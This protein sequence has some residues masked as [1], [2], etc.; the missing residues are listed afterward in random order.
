MTI[1]DCFSKGYLNKKNRLLYILPHI[2]KLCLYA[3]RWIPSPPLA[4]C[5][6]KGP[7]AAQGGSSTYSTWR[8]PL[9]SLLYRADTDR[10]FPINLTTF[11]LLNQMM[12]TFLYTNQSDHTS[13]MQ[14][15]S[16]GFT[17]RQF[18]EVS[19]SKNFAHQQSS[20]CQRS[21]SQ[22]KAELCG[23]SCWYCRPR[24]E[25]SEC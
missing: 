14:D 5:C 17:S 7:L 15:E 25:R 16:K 9:H 10:R 12:L 1:N 2:L 24:K 19:L 11:Y 21:P 4:N 8:S 3:C 18:L 23:C 22:G 13:Q 6:H 20:L